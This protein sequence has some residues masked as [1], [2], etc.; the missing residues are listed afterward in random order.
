VPDRQA[1]R[2]PRRLRSADVA[3]SQS[4]DWGDL[5]GR[6]A[7]VTGAS[8]G[9]GAA[10]ALA[11]ARAGA[12]V[13]LWARQATTLQRVAKTIHTFGRPSLVQVVDVTDAP[14]IRRAV[15]QALRRFGQLDI[16]VNNAGMWGGDPLVRLSRKIWSDVVATDLTSVFLVSQAVAPIMIRQRYGK[17]INVA[18]TSGFLAHHDGAAYC[19]AKAGVMHLS[20]VMAVEWGPYGIRVNCIAPG[21]FRTAMTS[22]VFADRAW[23]ARRRRQVPLRRFGEPDD[24]AGLAVFLASRGSD[25]ITGQTIVIDGGASLAVGA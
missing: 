12:S 13:V 22:D 5:T 17:I 16:V 7:L 24:L 19:T 4:S 23:L 20:R 18:S 10:M 6:V 2:K 9:L 11:L 8:R 14:A 3:L 21:L 1:S 15:T 25:H